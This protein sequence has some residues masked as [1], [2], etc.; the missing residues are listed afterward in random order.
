MS[1]LQFITGVSFFKVWRENG[2]NQWEFYCKRVP[3]SDE[4]S[5]CKRTLG[6]TNYDDLFV[7]VRDICPSYYILQEETTVRT[8]NKEVNTSIKKCH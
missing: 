2:T 4:I 6:Q 3:S 1:D 8:Y 5:L 7:P